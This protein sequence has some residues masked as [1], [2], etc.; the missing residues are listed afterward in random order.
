MSL[1][2]GNIMQLS[3]LWPGGIIILGKVSMTDENIICN[4]QYYS[5]GSVSDRWN[6]NAIVNTLPWGYYY[7][8][9]RVYDR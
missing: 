9:E 2:D 7:S 4:C 8:R 6:H 3:K 1:T 5:G